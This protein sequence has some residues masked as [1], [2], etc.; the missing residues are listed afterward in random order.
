MF[1]KQG[2]KLDK[3]KKK[4]YTHEIEMDQTIFILFIK[5]FPVWLIYMLSYVI[6]PSGPC[7]EGKLSILPY[8]FSRGI[9]CLYFG[10]SQMTFKDK[11]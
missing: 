3:R 9:L 6:E 11:M 4:D 2:L 5:L 8:L 1:R 7:Q 10:H